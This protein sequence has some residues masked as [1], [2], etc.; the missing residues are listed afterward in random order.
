ME[1]EQRKQEVVEQQTTKLKHK[2]FGR[3]F[4]EG[5]FVKTLFRL[6][7]PAVLQALISIVVLYVDNFSLALLIKDNVKATDAKTALGLATPVINFLV[8]VAISWIGGT[9][10]MMSQYYGSGDSQMTRKITA[11]RNW[12]LLLI[13]MPFVILMMTIPGQLIKITSGVDLSQPDQYQT[14][15][16]ARRYLFWTGI[17]FIPYVIAENL[18]H[19]LQETKRPI[20]SLLAAITGM[21]TNIILDP[22]C[23][24]FSDS[25]ELD[26]ML[27]ALS[28]GFARIVQT[29]FVLIYIIVKKDEH[30]WFF[31]SWRMRFSEMKIVVKNG[32][33]VFA[34]ESTYSLIN[35]ILMVC[36]LS[37]N[38]ANAN[39][40]TNVILLIEIT[41]VVWPGFGAASAVLIGSELGKGDIKQAKENAAHLMWWGVAFSITM[42]TL[43]LCA[44]FFI[45]Q[46]LSPGIN[47][48]DLRT[49]QELDWML[50][51]IVGSQGVFSIAYYAIK[52][53]GSKMILLID[54]GVM[55]LWAIMMPI[56]TFTGTARN[57]RPMWFLLLSESNQ[58]VKMILAVLMYKYYNWAKVLT[59]DRVE[60]ESIENIGEL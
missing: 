55:I 51:P 18:S 17:T 5:E 34:N 48:T 21:I 8:Y 52:S 29:L 24:V 15:S 11:F 45:N 50:L 47:S 32:I 14:W 44:S 43:I 9:G 49:A 30:L 54:C 39:A 2:V 26:M 56:I 1:Q 59:N 33:A 25:V 46:L 16:Y 58:I 42:C 12:T 36:L 27:V 40:I 3:A 19:G 57:W 38:P 22:I 60:I 41:T 6:F 28:T 20:V 7:V 23:I 35:L 4:G 37:F 13:I 10:I 31:N 53:G